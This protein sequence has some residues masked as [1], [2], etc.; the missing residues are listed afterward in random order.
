MDRLGSL[1]VAAEALEDG[2]SGQPI[3]NLS[4]LERE[5]GAAERELGPGHVEHEHQREQEWAGQATC[6]T[7]ARTATAHAATQP[8]AAANEA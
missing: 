1:V 4:Y 5:A 8:D 7:S 6:F 2:V 3:S